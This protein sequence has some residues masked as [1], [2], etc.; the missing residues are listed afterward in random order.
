MSLVSPR[1]AASLAARRHQMLA[2][3]DRYGRLL[4]A[5]LR[6]RAVATELATGGTPARRTP[7]RGDLWIRMLEDPVGRVDWS[8]DGA[9]VPRLATLADTEGAEP[10]PLAVHWA[11]AEEELSRRAA[12]DPADDLAGRRLASRLETA[13]PLD[14]AHARALSA[15]GRLAISDGDRAAAARALER[16]Y[17]Q[18]PEA[19]TANP[20]LVAD[21]L[22]PLLGLAEEP[23]MA[24]SYERALRASAAGE[25]AEPAAAEARNL[26]LAALA[27][28]LEATGRGLDALSILES[29]ETDAPSTAAALLERRA[30]IVHDLHLEGLL[31]GESARSRHR[32]IAAAHRALFTRYG[33]TSPD[34]NR[35]RAVT[36]LQAVRSRRTMDRIDPNDLETVER[37]A[38]DPVLEPEVRIRAHLE[39]HQLRMRSLSGREDAL[40]NA[41]DLIAALR[42]DDEL[43]TRML[44]E[45]GVVILEEI[46]AAR[47]TGGHLEATRIGVNRLRPIAVALDAGAPPSSGILDRV[48]TARILT[49]GRLLERA[50]AAWDNLAE[51]HPGTL[52]IL[53]GRSDALFRS[54]S[55]DELG[56]AMLVYRRLAQGDPGEVVPADVWWRAQLRQLLIL[57][58]VGRSLDRIG[59]RIER[60]RLVDPGL[61]GPEFREAFETLSA[62]LRTGRD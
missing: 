7:E 34:L 18:H 4:V 28:H 27:D 58:Q 47:R 43:A 29:I 38:A 35:S 32:G 55:E 57:E 46:D 24:G 19:P 30:R 13:D 23:W 9:L 12:G 41:P 25:E 53:V 48:A 42:I 22:G 21:L 62:R 20:G 1:A 10:L 15:L 14:P 11:L 5:D 2:D 31:A 51:E 3:D 44:L 39:R 54:K 59:P 52:E 17:L 8:F 16:L 26:R 45:T 40:E 6:E 61:G 50:L 60:L 49:E 56:E 37:I 33:E 36:F